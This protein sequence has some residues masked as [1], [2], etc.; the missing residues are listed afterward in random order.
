MSIAEH[1]VISI[2]PLARGPFVRGAAPRN[3]WKLILKATYG[4]SPAALTS[5]VASWVKK[6]RINSETRSTTPSS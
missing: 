6:M 4:E 2:E 1:N 3:G 5:T